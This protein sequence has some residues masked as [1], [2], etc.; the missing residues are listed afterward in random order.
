[1]EGPQTLGKSHKTRGDIAS[2]PRAGGHG[3]QAVAQTS[4]VGDTRDGP[5]GR[6]RPPV[7][8]TWA[9]EGGRRGE[10]IGAAL[11]PHPQG[12]PGLT[13]SKQ[14]PRSHGECSGMG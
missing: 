6:G 10:G 13:G 12:G 7:K 2:V 9:W 3:P 8:G 14:S 5:C 11:L 4:R 1:M